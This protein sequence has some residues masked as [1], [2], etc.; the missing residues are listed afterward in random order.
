MAAARVHSQE[1]ASLETRSN[2][3]DLAFDPERDFDAQAF[4]ERV[5]ARHRIACRQFPDIDPQELLTILASMMRPF[6]TGKRFFIRKTDDG[7]YII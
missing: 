7:S 3:C 6:G 5:M 2:S 4:A 1:T